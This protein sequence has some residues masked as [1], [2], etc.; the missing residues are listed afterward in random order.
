V[1][2]E[3]LDQVR[4]VRACLFTLAG[5]LFAVEVR[6][7]REVVVLEEYTTVPLAPPHLVGVANLRG[8]ILPIL[9]I[10]PLLGLAGQRVGRGSKVLVIAAG[11]V[12]V[13]V[14]IEGV[15]GLEWFADPV[16]F[17][18]AARR[19]HGELGVGLLERKGRLVTLLNA[20]KILE[21]LRLGVPA[22]GD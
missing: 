2:T 17:G 13:A 14:A 3:V 18:D 16:A 22:K 5:E 10:R 19:Q 12:Q 11:T 6:H 20:P 4:T 9:D 7:A 1:A 8:Y 21:A 15:L